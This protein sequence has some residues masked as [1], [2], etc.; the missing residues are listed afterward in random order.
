MV[1]DAGSEYDDNSISNE[2]RQVLLH[3]GY[4]LTKKD[5]FINSIN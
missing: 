2:I 3:R 5:F 4:E 1:K